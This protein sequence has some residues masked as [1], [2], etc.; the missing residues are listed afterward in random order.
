M[1][2]PSMLPDDRPT[3]PVTPRV[4][5]ESR[6]GALRRRLV[7][8]SVLAPG[9]AAVTGA[10]ATALVRDGHLDPAGQGALFGGLVFIGIMGVGIAGI[11]ASAEAPSIT[12]HS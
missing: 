7:L 11:R 9:V 2:D 6:A 3:S 12:Q 4:T 1:P 8:S 5:A 10:V